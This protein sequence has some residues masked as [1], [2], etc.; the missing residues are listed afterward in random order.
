[1]T[2]ISRNWI[3]TLARKGEISTYPQIL[4]GS[5]HMAKCQ[6]LVNQA[7]EQSVNCTILSASL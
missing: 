4:N 5:V 7:E 2:G 1:M 3:N 6:Q